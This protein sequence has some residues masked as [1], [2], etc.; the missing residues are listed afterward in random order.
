MSKRVFNP[1]ERAEAEAKGEVAPPHFPA[2]CLPPILRRMAEGVAELQRVPVAMTAPMVLAVASAS[3]GRGVRLKVLRGREAP[4]NL[5]VCVCKESGTGGSSAFRMATAPLDGMQA[6]I[7][8]QFRS[9]DL[10]RL[11]AEKATLSIEMEAA[12][13][14]YKRAETDTD[15][16]QSREDLKRCTAKLKAVEDSMRPPLLWTSDST[17]ESLAEQLAANNDTLAQ[18]NPDAGDSFSSMLGCYRD[19]S[20]R[21]GSH[22]LWLKAFSNEAHTITRTRGT[23]HLRAPCL[24]MLLV[25]T[26]H[27]ARRHLEDKSLLETGFLGRLMLCDPQ[28][29]MSEG[30]FEEALARPSLGSDVSQPYEAAIWKALAVYHRPRGLE[31]EDWFPD[32][33]D[34][35]SDAQQQSGPPGDEEREPFLIDSSEEALRVMWQDSVRQVDTWKTA[36]QDRELVARET[37]MASRIALVMHVFAGMKCAAGGQ[38]GTWK[39]TSCRAHLEPLQA[40]TMRNAVRIRDWFKASL[41]TMMAG[42]KETRRDDLFSKIEGLIIKSKLECV[43]PRNLIERGMAKTAEAA[44]AMLDAFVKDG[45]LNCRQR[46]AKG[47]GRP[48]G[49]AYYLPTLDRRMKQAGRHLT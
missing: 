1:A 3:L 31:N 9:D 24:S 15:R 37:E 36:E 34:S 6:R 27:T 13:G 5:F 38:G 39:V 21:D 10:P 48:P 26:P 33:D 23:V 40:D 22:A 20:S 14:R 42:M 12:K 2:E 8:R 4:P 7:L 43:T 44:K 41:A 32:D 35:V 29:V 19:K 17:P 18:F 45:R 28:A 47:T 16:H 49:A 30:S 25:V 11:E 46:E